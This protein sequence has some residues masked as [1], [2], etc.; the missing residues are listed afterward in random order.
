MAPEIWRLRNREN[1]AQSDGYT[2][3]VDLWSFGLLL[4]AVFTGRE[5]FDDEIHSVPV[6][7]TMFAYDEEE[8]FMLPMAKDFVQR[9][10]TV[11]PSDRACMLGSTYNGEEIMQRRV[12]RKLSG[13]PICDL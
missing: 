2:W 12:A 13:V 1:C 7:T 5:P 3:T 4:Y 11:S 9:L 6:G 8:W 10:L